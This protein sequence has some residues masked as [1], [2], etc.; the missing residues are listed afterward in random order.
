VGELAPVV[1][2]LAPAVG[3]LAPVVDELAP[4][5]DDLP[6]EG[7]E[8]GRLIVGLPA[9]PGVPRPA[10]ALLRH[11]AYPAVRTRGFARARQGRPAPTE[12]F[13]TDLTVPARTDSAA[14]EVWTWGDEDP[15]QR[16][17]G[18]ALK[19]CLSA[20]H[21]RHRAN[22]DVRAVGEGGNRW[23]GII[24]PFAGLLLAPGRLPTAKPTAKPAAK[25]AAPGPAAPEP[26]L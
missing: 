18:S 7:V 5:V 14:S 23:L 6:T 8:L 12:P 1:D 21:P 17:T 9:K 22:P 20:T 19:F 26:A 15:R 3:E 2:E 25:P 16:V 24:Q 13:P 11:G 10:T 4:V